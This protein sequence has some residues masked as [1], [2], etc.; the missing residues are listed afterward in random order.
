MSAT[1]SFRLQVTM[2]RKLTKLER[3]RLNRMLQARIDCY[4]ALEIAG[5]GIVDDGLMIIRVKLSGL[6]AK[7]EG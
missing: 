7:K 1:Y 5:E 3:Q 2:E 6:A 4:P